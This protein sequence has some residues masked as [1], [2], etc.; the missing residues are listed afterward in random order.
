M[1]LPKS[2]YV[3]ASYIRC[4]SRPC[5][6]R[7]AVAMTVLLMSCIGAAAQDASLPQA[8][9]DIPLETDDGT[10]F[11]LGDVTLP[12]VG[13]ALSRYDFVDAGANV[14]ADPSHG[15]APFVRKVIRQ[16]K[17]GDEVV[18]IVHVGDS[19]VRGHFFPGAVKGHLEQL[20]GADAVV[21]DYEV[22]DYG[23]PGISRETGRDGVVYQVYGINGAT[24]Q[25]F[26][27]ER[28]VDEIAALSPDLLIVSLGTNE[29]VGAKYARMQ[30][31]NQLDQLMRML[32]A[33]CPSTP[34]LLT[35]PPG[36]YRR[37]R[38]R[39][40]PNANVRLAAATITGYAEE[41]GYAWWDLYGVAGGDRAC[42]N[43]WNNGLMQ[44]DHLHFTKEGYWLM[45][46][47]LYSAIVNLIKEYVEHRF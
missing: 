21:R 40:Q 6:M 27:D 13:D 24:A 43:W 7:L 23:T 18:R 38:G 42:V 1:L 39:Y 31:K 28:H 14:I 20:L 19:H 33:R 46:D 16:L 26:S 22:F 36:A 9:P 29:S 47:L 32:A 37:V 44:R 4:F 12:E 45:G 8:S 30:H 35:T 41:K 11:E 2:L 25:R 5:L 3:F 10:A 34:V 15:L 17:A